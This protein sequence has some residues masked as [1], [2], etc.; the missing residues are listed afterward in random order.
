MHVRKH[1]EF[2]SEQCSAILS[3]AAQRA[4][5]PK[6]L[7]ENSPQHP[8]ETEHAL[9]FPEGTHENSPG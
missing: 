2:L 4:A 8:L 7:P 6:D 9:K 3:G 1:I 5:Q